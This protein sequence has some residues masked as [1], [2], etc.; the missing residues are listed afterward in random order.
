MDFKFKTNKFACLSVLLHYK[1]HN[2]TVVELYILQCVRKEVFLK[3]VHVYFYIYSS[4]PNT[5]V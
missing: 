4:F 5:T 3:H 1:I 2:D